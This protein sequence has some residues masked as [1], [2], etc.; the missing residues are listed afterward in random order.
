[1]RPE[2]AGNKIWK[3]LPRDLRG[4]KTS[5]VKN[6]PGDDDQQRDRSLGG[7]PLGGDDTY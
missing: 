2:V 3:R 4:C 1:M 7:V 6:G 5:S